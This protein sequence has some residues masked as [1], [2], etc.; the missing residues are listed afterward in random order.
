M[1][2]GKDQKEVRRS[3]QDSGLSGHRS[4]HAGARDLSGQSTTKS[5]H[6]KL[7]AKVCQRRSGSEG[8]HPSVRARARKRETESQDRRVDDAYRSSK[9]NGRLEKAADKRQFIHH[10]LKKFGSVSKGCKATGLAISSYYYKPKAKPVKKAKADADVR[11]LIESVQAQ[12][13]FY[14]HRRIHEW[15]ERKRGIT[16]NK[17]K[18][19]RIMRQHGL[20]A[21][22]WR[23][24]KVKTTDSN[25]EHG[26]A[27]NLLPGK[28][29]TD[30]NQVWVTDITY[31]RI[32]TGFVYLA[33]I[34]DLYSRKVVGWAIS[35][36]IDSALCLKALDDAIE[37]RRPAAGLVHHSDRGVQY[38]CDEYCARLK[39]HE[40]IASMSAK[41]YCYD[42]AFM[43]SFFKTLKAEEVYLTEYEAIED[44]IKSIPKFIEAVYNEKRLHSS[45]G[46]FSPEEFERLAALGLLKKHGIHPVMQIPGK[47]SK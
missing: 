30:I 41:G 38:A 39:L 29:I 5:C 22:I 25:H 37:K 3:V 31:I 1:S 34:L 14:G 18:I 36:R 28:K 32:L 27:P 9:K 40:M 33:A 10:N 21:L 17:K 15:L 12:F 2:Y 20:Q 23:G 11:D 35:T 26:Y 47:P 6:R 19:L 44:V 13:P 46:Y 43:E 45:L 8:R 42:N 16:I 24:F 4:R 7:D